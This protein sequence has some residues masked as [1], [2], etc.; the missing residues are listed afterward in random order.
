[1][2]HSKTLCNQITTTIRIDED[3]I[4]HMVGVKLV[5]DGTTHVFAN[6][7]ETQAFIRQKRI[8]AETKHRANTQ[9]WDKSRLRD[10]K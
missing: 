10:Y 3:G 6:P 2:G 9:K 1:M 8:E 7:A 5:F 4:K